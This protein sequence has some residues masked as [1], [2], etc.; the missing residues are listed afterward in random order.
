VSFV[1]PRGVRL[2]VNLVAF[3]IAWFACVIGAARGA[4]G[5]GIAAVGAAIALHF[6]LSPARGREALRTLAA[7]A[8]GMA[9]E[10]TLVRAGIVAYASPEPLA[11]WAPAWIL[12]LWALFA[13][14]LGE[15]L[16][17]LRGRPMLASALGAVG[18]ALSFAS[19]ERLGACSLPDATRSLFVIAAG[20][21]VITPA[22]VELARRLELPRTPARVTA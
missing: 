11:A 17:W 5:I 14:A 6:L 9:W 21:S 20:W 4:A 18:G 8:I 2:A 22:L 13:T 19:A 12:A 7:L 15:P 1:T 16:R 10:T 3:Q